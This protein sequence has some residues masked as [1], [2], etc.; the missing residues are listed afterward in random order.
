MSAI[1]TIALIF[2]FGPLA[3]MFGEPFF[4]EFFDILGWDSEDWAAPVMNWIESNTAEMMLMVGLGA[5]VWVH[6]FAQVLLKRFSRPALPPNNLNTNNT[7][8]NG[9]R[10]LESA[11]SAEI[12]IRLFRLLDRIVSLEAAAYEANPEDFRKELLGVHADRDMFCANGTA[13]EKWREFQLAAK[14]VNTA[15][16]MPEPEL[17]ISPEELLAI[18]RRDQKLKRNLRAAASDL[19]AGLS[20]IS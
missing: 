20:P 3:A 18:T 15:V 8:K 12:A 7:E 4:Q 17:G 5:G 6:Y 13:A 14:M 1:R 2:F 19:I 9:A 11:Y 16:N 10:T